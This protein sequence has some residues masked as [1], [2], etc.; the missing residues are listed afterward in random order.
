[1][2]RFARIIREASIELA[3]AVRWYEGQRSGLGADFLEAVSAGLETLAADPELGAAMVSGR[4]ERRFLVSR[5]PYQIVY[6]PMPSAL[7]I[8][9]VAHLRRRPGCRRNRR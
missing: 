7:V 1:V 6:Q 2:R 4:P 9:A 3:E 5:S 8:L